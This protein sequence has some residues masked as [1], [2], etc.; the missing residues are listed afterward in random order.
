[1]SVTNKRDT[2]NRLH[3]YNNSTNPILSVY[4]HLPKE[5]TNEEITQS[6]SAL[7]KH[8]L[9]YK[10]RRRAMRNIEYI[11]GFLRTFRK[12]NDEQSLAFF[13]AGD[14]LFEVIHLPYAVANKAVLSHIPF[15]Q[16]L[17]E[18]ESV[19][20]KYLFILIDREKARLFIM[21]QGII[22]N[23][24]EVIDKSVPQNVHQN[25]REDMHND[26][27]Q[28]INRHIQ[29]HL[30]RHF[31][32]IVQKVQQFVGHN[33]ITGVIIGGHK[34]LFQGFEAAL[35]K[36]LHKIIVGEFITELA[37]NGNDLVKKSK[38]IIE[39]IDKKFNNEE[40]PFLFPN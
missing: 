27:E 16:P 38:K 15:L 4:F 28:K 1:M 22:E 8:D 21:S 19:Y 18:Q 10:E 39:G 2:L 35:P 32:T 17:L 30:H 23:A 25:A 37:V 33:S 34:N 14:A 20:R 3:R 26:R 36:D 12:Q 5:E 6:L 24:V 29:D 40:P 11:Q 13:S 7:L 31:H 9:S